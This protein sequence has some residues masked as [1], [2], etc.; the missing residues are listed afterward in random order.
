MDGVVYS[1]TVTYRHPE[2]I[3]GHLVEAWC[4]D[5]YYF[6]NAHA[7]WEAIEDLRKQEEDIKFVVKDTLSPTFAMIWKQIEH[8]RSMSWAGV[9]HSR[10]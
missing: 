7:R 5:T 3:A 9:P 10:G 8:S 6:T 1:L 2:K 4:S